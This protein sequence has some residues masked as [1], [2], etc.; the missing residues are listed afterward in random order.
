MGKPNSKK[1]IEERR[2]QILLLLSRGY[3]QSDI[4]REL[5]ITRMTMSRDMKFINETSK[6][7]LFGLA[8]ETLSTMYFDCVRGIN[9]VQKECWRI[10]R[11]NDNNR[12]I[13]QWHR[14]AALKLIRKCNDTKFEMFQTAPALMEIQRLQNEVN[15]IKDNT[16]DK[17]GKLIRPLSDKELEDLDKP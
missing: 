5:D 13:Q 16:F 14:M 8:K 17:D 12:E 7:G 2:E 10:Y 1:R 9:E 6:R 11:N 3:S 4:C 15:Q